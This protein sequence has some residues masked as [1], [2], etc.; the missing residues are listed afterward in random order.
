MD[1]ILN[2]LGLC[3]RA[4]KLVHGTD[5]VVEG[6]K[7]GKV[8]YVFL[9]NDASANTIKKITDKAKYYSVEVN[10]TYTSSEISAA[11]GK[12][13]RMAVGIIDANFLKILK[14]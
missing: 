11:I 9:A 2:N 13:G 7:C 3:L 4:G 12:N 6:I 8:L 1:K 14:K 10:D 5:A